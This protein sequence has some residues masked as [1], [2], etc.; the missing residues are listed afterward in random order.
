MTFRQIQ[1]ILRRKEC[2]SFAGNNYRVLGVEK[3][4]GTWFAT[5]E[6]ELG[7]QDRLLLVSCSLPLTIPKTPGKGKKR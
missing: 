3:I 6:D 1:R 7:H 4:A 5:I 2:L